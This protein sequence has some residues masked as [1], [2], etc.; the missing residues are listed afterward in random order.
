MLQNVEGV[1][2]D[3]AASGEWRGVNSVPAQK[4]AVGTVEHVSAKIIHDPKPG[5][6]ILFN[7]Q[8]L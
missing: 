3:S 8:Y 7:D 4:K 2:E 5:F 1:G 6:L